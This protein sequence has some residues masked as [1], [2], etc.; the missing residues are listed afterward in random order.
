M[1]A[2]GYTNFAEEVF[3][4]I[5]Q[6]KIDRQKEVRFKGAIADDIVALLQEIIKHSKDDL[7][8]R[9]YNDP[10]FRVSEIIYNY[11]DNKLYLEFEDE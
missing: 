11:E 7:E 4:I 9:D 1:N 5:D 10:D 2:N 3:N 6:A 8:L